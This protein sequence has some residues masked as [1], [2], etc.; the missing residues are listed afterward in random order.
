MVLKKKPLTFLHTYHHGA[1]ALLCYTQLIGITS[2]SWV[3]ITLNLLVHVVMYWYYFQAA[4]GVRIWWKKWI[5]RL[6]IIQFVIDLGFV[7]FASYT[8]FTS[9]YFPNLPSAGSCAGEEFAAFAGM[10]ILS[11]YLLLFVSF[12]LATYKKEKDRAKAGREKGN[13]RRMSETATKATIDMARMEVPDA[14]QM[15]GKI[16]I[17]VPE[18][19]L[20]NR[21]ANGVANGVSHQRLQGQ[22]RPDG[23]F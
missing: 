3:P 20:A 8:Y 2:V 21:S 12:Y 18:N 4:R 19:G 6:Q 16:H 22:K 10:G 11:S 9:T 7:Y 1:T 17:P 14:H 15:G 13:P 5:T 23:M